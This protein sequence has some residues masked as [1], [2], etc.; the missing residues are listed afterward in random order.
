MS[1]TQEDLKAIGKLLQSNNKDLKDFIAKENQELA[2]MTARELA[3][4][5]REL[6]TLDRLEKLEK[7]MSKV[8]TALNL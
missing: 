4:I 7:K 8:T 6:N 3:A 2:A 5:R 1:L